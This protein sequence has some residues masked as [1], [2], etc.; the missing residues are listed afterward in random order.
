M[1][2]I[3]APDDPT[4]YPYNINTLSTVD[5]GLTRNLKCDIKL[6]IL[7]KFNSNHLPINIKLTNSAKINCRDRK[8]FNYKLAKWDM[9]R[10]IIN[11]NLVIDEKILTQ[12]DIDNSISNLVK[13]IQNTNPSHLLRKCR[14]T[15]HAASGN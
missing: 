12:N 14:K 8:Y 10:K 2:Q 5:V 4:L 9:F 3:I 6:E 11:E 1:F 15:L 13:M 7:N